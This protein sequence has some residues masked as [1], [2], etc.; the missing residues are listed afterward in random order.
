MLIKPFKRKKAMFI[1]FKLRRRASQCSN[2]KLTKMI[3]SPTKYATR[4]RESQPNPVS[5]PHMI[6]WEMKAN[7]SAL[8]APQRTTSECNP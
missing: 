6:K 3:N 1:Q 4:N 2:S 7:F 8:S 5:K